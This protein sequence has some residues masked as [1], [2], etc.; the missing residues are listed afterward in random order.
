M[1]I[2]A[3]TPKNPRREPAPAPEEF[4]GLEQLDRDQLDDDGASVPPVERPDL[5]WDDESSV[6]RVRVTG[7]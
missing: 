3:S 2:L 6:S 7:A 4:P 5:D 1:P